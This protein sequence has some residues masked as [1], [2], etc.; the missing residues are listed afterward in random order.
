MA[1]T[2]AACMR[3]LPE[4][5]TEV[6]HV[7]NHG[8]LPEE[9]RRLQGNRE[10]D[11]LRWRGLEESGAWPAAGEWNLTCPDGD[12]ISRFGLIG[13]AEDSCIGGRKRRPALLRDLKRALQEMI[14]GSKYQ[15][16]TLI[17]DPIAYL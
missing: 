16:H 1:Q 10:S 8:G 7:L 4:L 2:S 11:S 15:N 5:G 17:L 13:H 14:M 6:R 9:T 12:Q 3:W